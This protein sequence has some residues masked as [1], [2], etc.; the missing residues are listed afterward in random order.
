[1]ELQ[2]IFSKTYAEQLQR[3]VEAN[4]ACYE[5]GDFEFDKSKELLIPNIKH[6]SG[7]CEKMMAAKNDAE[8]GRALYEAY[9]NLSP[10]QASQNAFWVYLAHTELF[11]Y[12]KKRWNETNKGKQYILDHWFLSHGLIRHALAGLWWTVYCSYDNENP[13]DPYKYSDFLFSNYTLRVVRLGP[14]TIMRHKEA[15]IGIASYLMDHEKDAVSNSLEDRVN[16]TISH[17][18]QM[19]ATKQLASLDRHF[20]Y[21]ELKKVHNDLITHRHKKSDTEEA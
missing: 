17:F 21:D 2:K 12:V 13:Q 5:N 3:D 8:A 15:V 4:L 14:S 19:G 7:L 20:F 10:L 6:P 1:M 9:K 18:N 16:F 11:P